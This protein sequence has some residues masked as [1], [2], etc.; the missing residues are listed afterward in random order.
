MGKVYFC[1]LALKC[2]LASFYSHK[3]SIFK[4]VRKT[5]ENEENPR[6]SRVFFLASFLSRRIGGDVRTGRIVA[7]YRLRLLGS[8]CS[9]LCGEKR[10]KN[11]TQSFSLGF[12]IRTALP[13]AKSVRV[14]DRQLQNKNAPYWVRFCFGGDDRI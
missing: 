13:L 4:K 10:R 2:R 12:Q 5:A 3:N 1:S 9:L 11:D 8:V 7:A 14:G 6:K